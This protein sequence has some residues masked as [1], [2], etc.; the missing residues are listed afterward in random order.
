[1]SLPFDNGSRALSD[2]YEGKGS[3]IV[4]RTRPP[5]LETPFEVFDKGLITPN[6]QHYVRWHLARIPRIAADA[7]RLNVHGHLYC[8]VSLSMED[9]RRSY[10]SHEVTAVSQCAGNSRG[11]FAPRVPGSQWGHGAMANAV[12]RGVRLG[13]VLRRVG[14][15]PGSVCVR[16]QG[17][18]EPALPA[19]PT[20]RKTLPIDHAFD[21]DI[22]LAYEVNGEPLPHLNGFP[23]RLVVPGWYSTYWV[24]MVGSIEVLTTPDDSYWMTRA[25]LLNRVPVTRMGPR[26]FVTSLTEG[27]RL[28]AGRSLEV[29]GIAFG[30]DSEV[31]AVHWRAT[32]TDPWQPAN[33][34]ARTGRYGFCRWT[35]R[36][37]PEAGHRTFQ[38]RARNSKGELQPERS[39]WNAPGYGYNGIE[40][41]AYEAV[42]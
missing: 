10:R 34:T 40:T 27:A 18:D 5:V 1:M 21:D 14:I 33:I 17:L 28:V 31:T 38:V 20:Y 35:V 4:Q 6:R 12:W 15:R 13:D 37:R 36:L 32:A 16:F 22:L 19:T 3:M 30:G 24:K 42:A 9:L 29:S 25:Y 23:L 39:H 41:L 26:S 2:A 8:P 11:L 7:Y